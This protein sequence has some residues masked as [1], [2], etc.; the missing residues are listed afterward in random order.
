MA[1]KKKPTIVAAYNLTKEKKQLRS[2]ET[3]HCVILLGCIV[4][5]F[6][7]LVLISVLKLNIWSLIILR[8]LIQCHISFY[9]NVWS[10]CEA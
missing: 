1:F 4:V 7:E 2:I 10:N 3:I 5:N 8:V 6:V 9:S